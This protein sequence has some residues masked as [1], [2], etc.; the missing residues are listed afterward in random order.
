VLPTS[1]GWQAQSRAF[2]VSEDANGIVTVEIRS[3]EDASGLERQLE[4]LG[5]PA[6]VYDLPSGKLCNPRLWGDWPDLMTPEERLASPT[7]PSARWTSARRGRGVHVRLRFPG[8][9]GRTNAVGRGGVRAAQDGQAADQVPSIAVEWAAGNV[10]RCLLVDGSI[11]DWPFQKGAAPRDKGSPPAP[12][13]KG[14][15]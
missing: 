14:F 13:G 15:P 2:A 3:I 9:P 6:A 4:A 8:Y 7:R 5:I 1:G 12:P 10:D 11:E